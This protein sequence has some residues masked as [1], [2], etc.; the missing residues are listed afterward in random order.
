MGP[1]LGLIAT[2]YSRCD[3]GL[4]NL[5]MIMGMGLMGIY[6]SSLKINC[7][8]LS[9]NYSGTVMALING[10]GSISGVISPYLTS[11]LIPD[12]SRLFSLTFVSTNLRFLAQ[13]FRKEDIELTNY[14]PTYIHVAPILVPKNQ[15]LGFIYTLYY[16]KQY[17]RMPLSLI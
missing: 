9:P 16:E 10:I 6:Y 1:A 12:V 2:T 15:F 14:L 8:D 4:V 11:Y 17:I 13:L 3:K 5:Y 7:L